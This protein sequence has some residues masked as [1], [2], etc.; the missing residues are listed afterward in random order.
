MSALVNTNWKFLVDTNWKFLENTNWKFIVM[1]L[2]LALALTIIALIA[3]NVVDFSGLLNSFNGLEIAGEC[4]TV[5]CTS[6]G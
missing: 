3:F 4:S 5:S 6:N 1:V 2:V